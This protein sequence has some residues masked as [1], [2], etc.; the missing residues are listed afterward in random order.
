MWY[1][2]C[3]CVFVNRSFFFHNAPCLFHPKPRHYFPTRELSMIPDEGEHEYPESPRTLSPRRPKLAETSLSISID[4]PDASQS[5][6]EFTGSLVLDA[7]YGRHV[8]PQVW[9][10]QGAIDS[11]V[12]VL[13][14]EASS[15]RTRRLRSRRRRPE[16]DAVLV[17]EP[18][19]SYVEQR[20]IPLVVGVLDKPTIPDG[21]GP[22]AG[23]HAGESKQPACES[24]VSDTPHADGDHR[25]PIDDNA[26]QEENSEGK[27]AEHMVKT[28]RI[29]P[30]DS[31][32]F[33]HG[34][35][36][37]NQADVQGH[38][39]GGVAMPSSIGNTVPNLNENVDTNSVIS[40]FFTPSSS[41]DADAAMDVVVDANSTCSYERSISD[42]SSGE[43]YMMGSEDIHVSMDEHVGSGSSNVSHSEV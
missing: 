28:F 17:I 27:A 23:V 42:Q 14:Q 43:I 7:T 40:D 10:D 33:N 16:D 37:T 36:P 38:G 6:P 13:K 4:I 18:S 22:H 3:V 21:D 24:K 9:A 35:S 20:D 25:R 41:S 29:P 34:A 5:R 30:R 32:D 15:Q 39:N 19:T 12:G 1:D 11:S 8:E 31:P 26:H 2:L